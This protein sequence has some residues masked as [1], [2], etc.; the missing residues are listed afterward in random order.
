MFLK[1]HTLYLLIC[2][3]SS[4]WLPIDSRIHVF[5]GKF[6]PAEKILG[7]R[8]ILKTVKAKTRTPILIHTILLK[9]NS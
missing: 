7:L 6:L 3:F 1:T 9:K 8:T 4:T 5:Y 2:T